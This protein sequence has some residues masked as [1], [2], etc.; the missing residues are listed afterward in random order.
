MGKTVKEVVLERLLKGKIMDNNTL[1]KL[2]DRNPHIKARLEV[3]LNVT[4]NVSGEF[5][6]ADDAEDAIAEG[7]RKMG[8]DLLQNWAAK[9]NVEKEC[10]ARNNNDLRCHS[11][12]NS[13]GEQPLEKLK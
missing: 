2:L 13:I 11:K 10:E 9:Q 8:Q 3:L 1:I 12:K 6:R 5:K 4:E 7:V